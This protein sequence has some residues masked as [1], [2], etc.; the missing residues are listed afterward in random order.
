MLARKDY[1][2]RFPM[3]PIVKPTNITVRSDQAGGAGWAY[4]YRPNET[5]STPGAWTCNS[6]GWYV[7][8]VG[9]RA[10]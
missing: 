6:G 4:G 7:G 5:T 1:G 9:G 8:A 3:E 2:R 10:A